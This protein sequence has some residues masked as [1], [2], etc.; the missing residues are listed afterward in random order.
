M[1][2]LML[3]VTG[4]GGRRI[5]QGKHVVIQTN[6][7]SRNKDEKQIQRTDVY[8]HIAV[9]SI[10]SWRQTNPTRETCRGP[11]KGSKPRQGCKAGTE[12]GRT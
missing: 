10:R 1:N 6:E 3:K 5:Q 4:V 9:E 2:I 12:K 8:K 11:N 7:V